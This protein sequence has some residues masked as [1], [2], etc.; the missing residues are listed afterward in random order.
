MDEFKIQKSFLS[1]GWRGATIDDYPNSKRAG[2]PQ[3][4]F[5][6]KIILK[7]IWKV[8]EDESN[9]IGGGNGLKIRSIN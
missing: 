6:L 5:I 3:K 8:Y 1:T 2:A 4:A 9:N 7:N